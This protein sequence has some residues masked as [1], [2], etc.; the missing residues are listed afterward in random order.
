MQQTTRC[1]QCGTKLAISRERCPKCRAFVVRVD[2]AAEAAQSRTFVRVAAAVISTFVVIVA[3]LWMTQR[4]EPTTA[5]ANPGRPPADP[6]AGRRAAS[7]AVN[8]PSPNETEERAFLD[9]SAQGAIS[10]EGGDYDAAL[11]RFEEAVR[12]HPQDAES[13]SNLGQ[14]LVR[15]QRVAEAVPYFERAAALNPDRWTY[16]F[17]LARALGLLQRWDESIASYRRAQVL[18]PDDYVT[19][20][21]LALA[22]HKKGDDTGAIEEYKKAIALNPAEA[23]FRMALA[24]SY[25]QMKK[26][27]DAA[28]QYAEYLRLSP[29][30]ADAEKVRA[31]IA[32]LASPARALP[33]PTPAVQAP[34]PGQQVSGS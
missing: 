18:F 24:I 17:N 7:P 1:T 14:V 5:V 22:M 33:A 10:Y 11:T 8:A 30:A 26:T 16:R 2:K 27:E 12:Q 21:N 34:S 28:S 29:L 15:L 4:A 13:L 32:Q 19:T 20:F 31:R 3:A 6:L 25:E 23:S 9:S